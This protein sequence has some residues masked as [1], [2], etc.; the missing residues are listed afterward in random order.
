M[1]TNTYVNDCAIDL[2]EYSKIVIQLHEIS[3]KMFHLR[4]IIIDCL[5]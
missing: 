5:W 1:N 4:Y 3:I 2:R